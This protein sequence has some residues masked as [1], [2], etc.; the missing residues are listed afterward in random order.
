[1]YINLDTA[2]LFH[3]FD[4]HPQ[5]SRLSKIKAVAINPGNL[6]DSRDLRT[7]TPRTLEYM[8]KYIIGPLRPVLKLLS[9]PTLRTVSD[10][11]NDVAELTVGKDY[12]D[13]RGYFTLLKKSD[14]S[15]ES[16]DER[17]QQAMWAKTAQWANIDQY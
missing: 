10:A 9:V 14:S 12:A 5:D 4:Y 2:V 15:P 13:E 7:N 16:K 3:V 17:K 6:T 8:S 1:M 11:A